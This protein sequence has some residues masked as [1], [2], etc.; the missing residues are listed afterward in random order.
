M[1]NQVGMVDCLS[2]F[3][4]QVLRAFKKTSVRIRSDKLPYRFQTY[5]YVCIVV[6]K[7]SFSNI[8]I[9]TRFCLR[10]QCIVKVLF[11]RMKSDTPQCDKA[12]R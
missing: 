6:Q 5:K 7:R 4:Q 12:G 10:V 2:H 11:D 3:G 8:V 1:H 9:E